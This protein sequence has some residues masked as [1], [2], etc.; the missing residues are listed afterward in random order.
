MKI[1]ILLIYIIY[2]DMYIKT[3]F[4]IGRSV[5]FFSFYFKWF[6]GNLILF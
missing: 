3:G 4:F 6:K 1:E 5:H 2:E